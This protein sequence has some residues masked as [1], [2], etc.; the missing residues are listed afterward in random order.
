MA[1]W[2]PHATNPRY[3]VLEGQKDSLVR[4]APMTDGR[5]LWQFRKIVSYAASV[6]AAKE[7]VEAGA[8]YFE[9]MRRNPY[10]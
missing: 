2:K 7:Y 9:T 3:V 8:E 10:A 1:T 5:Y 4:T 6:A